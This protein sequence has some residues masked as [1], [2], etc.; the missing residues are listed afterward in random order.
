MLKLAGISS[1]LGPE[2]K[3]VKAVVP[4]AL[5]SVARALSPFMVFDG[6]KP[7]ARAEITDDQ[8][9]GRDDP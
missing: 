3:L 5:L 8:A 7:L 6:M 1:Q 9:A 4:P 2:A